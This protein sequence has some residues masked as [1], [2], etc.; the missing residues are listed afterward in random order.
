MHRVL[1]CER[2]SS[3][4]L[5]LLSFAALMPLLRF[6]LAMLYWA[7]SPDQVTKFQEGLHCPCHP[8]FLFGI[9]PDVFVYC[10]SVRAELNV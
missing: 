9:N 4:L 7:L 5:L 1:L 2:F 8:G 6:T 10:Y 3:T